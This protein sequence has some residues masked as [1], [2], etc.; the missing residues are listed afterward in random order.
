MSMKS[1]IGLA[2]FFLILATTVISAIGIINKQNRACCKTI[3]IN[4][5]LDRYLC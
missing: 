1:R 2:I 4:I 3:N 5:A